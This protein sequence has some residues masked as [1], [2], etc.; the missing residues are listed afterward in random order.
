MLLLNQYEFVRSDR[1]SESWRQTE[2]RVT[3]N[4]SAQQIT[5]NLHDKYERNAGASW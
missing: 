2:Y 1:K 5:A 4:Q 3:I